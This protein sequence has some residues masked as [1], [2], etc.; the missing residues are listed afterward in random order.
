M[1]PYNSTAS[2][3]LTLMV[4]PED[5]NIGAPDDAANPVALR[6]TVSDKIFIGQGWRLFGLLETGQEITIELRSSAAAEQLNIG[7]DT[8][9]WWPRERGKFLEY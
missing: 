3:S 5:M 2:D 9:V 8:V 4:R 1:L 7:D 6:V